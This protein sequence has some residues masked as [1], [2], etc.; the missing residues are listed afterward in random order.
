MPVLQHLPDRNSEY[1]S[2]TVGLTY[3][4]GVIMGQAARFVN[5]KNWQLNN[6]YKLLL[7][8]G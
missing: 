4:P 8:K 6:R 2:I 5:H 3:D 1:R 7:W